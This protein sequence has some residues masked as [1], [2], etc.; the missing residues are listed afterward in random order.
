[1]KIPNI[2]VPE[3]DLTSMINDYLED[4]MGLGKN[5][6]VHIDPNLNYMLCTLGVILRLEG[7]SSREIEQD[8][9]K[10]IQRSEE[11]RCVYIVDFF[12]TAELDLPVSVSSTILGHLKKEYAKKI[13]IDIANSYL[14]EKPI[15]QNG[16]MDYVNMIIGI[17]TENLGPNKVW[18]YLDPKTKLPKTITI[19]ID[20]ILEVEKQLGLNTVTNTES[21]RQTIRKIYG[22]KL[23]NDPYYDFMDNLELVEAVTNV[24]LKSEVAKA[25]SLIE[26]L[27]STSNEENKRLYEKVTNNMIQHHGYCKV[28]AEKTL[29]YFC[30]QKN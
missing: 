14:D 6:Q 16:V 20:Y 17:G 11:K 1:M 19:D 3:K 21:F 9:Q 27:A 28:C 4:G 5:Q 8:I 12:K 2:F 22:M 23:S 7:K 15:I 18:K 10:F 24:K 13:K 30:T 29:E 25:G 26:F